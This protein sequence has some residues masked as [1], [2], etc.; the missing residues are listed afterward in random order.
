MRFD[1]QQH[2]CACGI[3]WHARTMYACILDQHGAIRLQRNLPAKPA[4]FLQASAPAREDLGIAVACIFPWYGLAALGA[5]AGRPFVLGHA[6]DRQALPGGKAKDD[7][8]ASQHI[9]GRLR[10]GLRPQASV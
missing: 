10:G 7:Q 5:Q 6:L 8:R 3:D 4:T 1:T 2:P 9:A